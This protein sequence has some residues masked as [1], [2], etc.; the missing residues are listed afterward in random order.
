MTPIPTLVRAIAGGPPAGRGVDHVVVVG[1]ALD[2]LSDAW[3]RLGFRTTEIGVHPWGTINRTIRFDHSFVELLAIAEPGRIPP[4]ES[5]AFSFGGFVA[6]RLARRGEG[7]AMLA[8]ASDDPDADRAAFAAAGLGLAA[9]F[10]FERQAVAEDGSERTVGFDLTFATLRGSRIGES[11]DAGFFT[12]RHRVPDDFWDAVPP[13]HPNTAVGLSAIVAVAPDPAD[14]HIDLEAFAG[15]R[16]LRASSFGLALDL[17]RGTLE[18]LTPAAF[19]WRHGADS[20]PIEPRG[21]SLAGLRFAVADF[22]EAA[23]QLIAGG[24][25]VLDRAESFVVADVAGVAVAFEPASPRPP[26]E[27][28]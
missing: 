24:F 22:G 10:G 13:R 23:A 3:H 25:P 17:P 21:L 19:R 28:R 20:L 16:A 2:R 15:L 6:D 1:H 8:L 27:L 12:C 4:T 9:P 26:Q 18:V 5:G 11:C 7:L 14:Y